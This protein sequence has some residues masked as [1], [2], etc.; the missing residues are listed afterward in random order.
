MCWWWLALPRRRAPRAAQ[1][2]RSFWGGKRPE[3]RC[4]APPSCMRTRTPR[5]PPLQLFSLPARRPLQ[6]APLSRRSGLLSTSAP[7][8]RGSR[9]RV[10][11][12]RRPKRRPSG[13]LGC[14]PA[15]PACSLDGSWWR[16]APKRCVCARVCRLCAVWVL[17]L[18]AGRALRWAAF[19]CRSPSLPLP[20]PP[21][22]PALR[23]MLLPPLRGAPMHRTQAPPLY[24]PP[25]AVIAAAE[26]RGTSRERGA[27]R[28][29]FLAHTLCLRPRRAPDALLLCTGGAACEMCHMSEVYSDEKVAV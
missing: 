19:C 27:A 17:G 16:L 11:R 15:Q 1:R 21:S 8:A 9:R 23:L 24:R 2:A 6:R 20:L 29:G 26:P 14:P 13:A 3:P 10:R 28:G 18:R 4:C 12:L 22:G 5:R 7:C 25:A